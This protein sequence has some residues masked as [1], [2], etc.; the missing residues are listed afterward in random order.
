MSAPSKQ[1]LHGRRVL[2]VED[3][4]LVG[5]M[6]VDVLEDAGAVVLGP[7]TSIDEGLRMVADD[8][9][10][11]AVLD[12]NLSGHRSEPIARALLAREVPFL[13]STGYGAISD[14]FAHIPLLNK[15]YDPDGIVDSLRMLLLP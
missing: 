10:D 4:F 12:W 5:A 3:E 2:L 11:I 1:A 7:A 15:P 14:E 13:I 9:F 8:E 6:L